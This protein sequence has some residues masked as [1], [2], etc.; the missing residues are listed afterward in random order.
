[1]NGGLEQAVEPT[2]GE[3]RKEGVEEI[4]VRGEDIPMLTAFYLS[5]GRRVVGITG[6]DLYT[7]YLLS[8]D[9][10]AV[11]GGR[12]PSPAVTLEVLCREETINPRAVFG[13]PALCVMTRKGTGI[14]GGLRDP[15]IVA[16]QKYA[17]I[18]AKFIA[19][20]ARAGFLQN[21]VRTMYL[22]GKTEVAGRDMGAAMVID[23]VNEG[24]TSKRY[25]WEVLGKPLFL[26]D[27][28]VIGSAARIGLQGY[29]R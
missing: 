15:L 24:T 10:S 27:I 1:M 13:K 18:A 28:I 4:E 9:Y 2:I 16:N 3:L 29:A 8:P 7:N 14:E 21:N 11:Q 19:E 6:S 17:W 20:M 26:S 25:G 5:Q 22:A 12:K 23:I